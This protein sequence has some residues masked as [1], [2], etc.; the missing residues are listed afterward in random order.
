MEFSHYNEYGVNHCLI[1]R[2]AIIATF[3][4]LPIESLGSSAPLSIFLSFLLSF[5]N[6]RMNMSLIKSISVELHLNVLLA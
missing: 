3:S 6:T 4:A 1:E 5:S 2:M